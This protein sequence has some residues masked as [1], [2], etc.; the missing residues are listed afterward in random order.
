MDLGSQFPEIKN[1]KVHNV[2]LHDNEGHIESLDVLLDL[3]Y[4]GNFRLSIDADMVLGKKGFLSLKVQQI[5]GLARL[6]FTRKPYTHWSLSFVGEPKLELGVESQFQGRQMQ[7]NVTSLISNQIRK[8]IKRKHTLPNYKLRYKPFFNKTDDELETDSPIDGNLEVN[9]SELTRLM[10]PSHI[11]HVYCTIT[12]AAIPWV[13]ARQQDDK[14]LTISLDL[15]IH[16]AKNQQI[17]IVF[18]QTEHTVMV[19]AVIPNTPAAKAKLIKG[20]IL[21][22]IEGK[23]VSNI[24][25]VAKLIK[26]LNRPMFILRIER[27]V[28]GLIKND[29]V[30]E[31]YEVYEDFNDMNISFSKNTDSVQIGK[32]ITRKNSTER[33]TSSDSS[34]ANTPS[35]SPRK[36]GEKPLDKIRSKGLSRNNSDSK[37]QADETTP[38]LNRSLEHFADTDFI[39]H[40]TVDCY[41]NSFIRMDDLSNFKLSEASQ[42]L[43]LNVYGRNNEESI[44]LGYLNIPINSI[45]AECNESHLGHYL[46]Q[47]SLIPPDSPNV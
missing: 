22:S 27:I 45:I 41:M 36:T 15:E 39:Q 2:E 4:R 7:S 13:Q 24:S 18:K 8:A 32:K 19:E 1:L 17:G 42:Y 10:S 21:I 12:L 43:N 25:H 20:D 34:L 40:S 31:D 35:N 16:K 14:N 6:Q 9:I 11:T 28:P 3:Q 29:A 46:K 38:I 23:K 47:Y 37:S 30:L 44:L 33:A 26:S 5:S